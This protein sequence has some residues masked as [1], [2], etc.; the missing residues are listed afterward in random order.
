MSLASPSQ[1]SRRLYRSRKQRPCDACRR[2]KICCVREA[3]SPAC[4]LC[5]LRSTTCTYYSQPNIRRR[6]PVR[7]QD[8]TPESTSSLPSPESAEEWTP[9]FVGF[10]SDQD[11]YI[12][13]HC[14]FKDDSF[15]RP[16]WRCRRMALSTETGKVAEIPMHFAV[17]P[18]SHLDTTEQ[19]LP[20][21]PQ[22]NLPIDLYDGLIR[23][24]FDVVHISLPL[25]DGGRF[26][27]NRE[28]N[29]PLVAIM[30]RLARHFA[31]RIRGGSLVDKSWPE[32][33]AYLHQAVAINARS[34]RLETIEMGLLFIQ[35]PLSTHRAPNLPGLWPL[36]GSLVGMAHDL[37]LNVDPT[38]W[39]IEE[40]ERRRRIRIWWTLYIADK[41]NAL[42]SGRPSYIN[43][44][45]W[46]VPTVTV[47]DM[48]AAHHQAELPEATGRMFVAMAHLTMI[49]SDVLG[50][51]YS[52]RAI[53]NNNEEPVD[54]FREW[55]SLMTRLEKFQQGHVNA[56][57]WPEEHVRNPT[58][59]FL[60]YLF[61]ESS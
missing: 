60:N 26:D 21:C 28:N 29:S 44:D 25:L 30:C 49:L 51:F 22:L 46:D 56:L 24:F 12:L 45:N 41:W 27:E 33:R 8:G 18:D 43:E 4:S 19:G 37:G 13:R 23:T 9:L 34:P 2:R 1:S 58:G 47:D 53:R 17:V 14:Q 6:R 20:R 57:E 61:A 16:D 11:P 38:G 59:E 5:T 15:D 48:P 10:S 3:N 7:Q 35:R 31:P 32:W 55:D 50:K 39:A 42:G 54:V 36:I 40:P 52:I